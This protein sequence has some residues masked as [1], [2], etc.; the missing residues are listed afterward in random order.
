MQG[1][2]LAYLSPQDLWMSSKHVKQEK[3]LLRGYGDRDRERQSCSKVSS[4]IGSHC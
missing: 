2:T 3:Q 4:L 1:L